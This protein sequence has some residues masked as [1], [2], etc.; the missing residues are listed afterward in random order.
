M[1]S[2]GRVACDNQ[3][4]VSVV[5]ATSRPQL[6]E[7]SPDHTPSYEGGNSQLMIL[8][9]DCKGVYIPSTF[10]PSTFTG[11]NSRFPHDP[12]ESPLT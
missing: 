10:I 2:F 6:Q 4:E 11:I 7:R 3:T 9:G 8:G 1:H 12:K 5:R